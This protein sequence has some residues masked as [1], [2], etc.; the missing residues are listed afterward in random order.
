M[1]NL[2]NPKS[3]VELFRAGRRG[4]AFAES[5]EV[6]HCGN[7]LATKLILRECAVGQCFAAVA[8]SGDIWQKKFE[9]LEIITNK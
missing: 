7:M 2:R 6:Y 9:T 4:G 5:G 1:R 3:F 8:W